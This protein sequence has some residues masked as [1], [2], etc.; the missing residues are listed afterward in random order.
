MAAWLIVQT[1]PVSSHV[2]VDAARYERTAFKVAAQLEDAVGAAF[3]GE[4][5][6]HAGDPLRLLNL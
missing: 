3:G 1:A 2:A 5:T 6:I 4:T